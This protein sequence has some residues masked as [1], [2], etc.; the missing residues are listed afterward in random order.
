MI[1]TTPAQIIRSCL[2]DWNLVSYPGTASYKPPGFFSSMP[3]APDQA[4]CVFDTKGRDFGRGT[5]EN[6]SNVHPSIQICVRWVDEAEGHD[7]VNKI[8]VALDTHFPIITVLPEDGSSW[9]IM[10]IR[11]TSPILMLGE[12]IGKRRNFWTINALVVF[13]GPSLG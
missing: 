9:Y 3:D 12:E 8:A 13:E 5:R 7:R 10:N 4:I 1:T 2:I 6:L 11:R